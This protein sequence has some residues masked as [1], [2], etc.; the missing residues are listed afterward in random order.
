ME[1][2]RSVVKFSTRRLAPACVPIRGF[3]TP[4]PHFS[5]SN[6]LNPLFFVLFIPYFGALTSHTTIRDKSSDHSAK[7][8]FANVPDKWHILHATT[9]RHNLNLIPHFPPSESA[10]APARL[11]DG[12]VLWQPLR[13][14][15]SQT[16]QPLHHHPPCRSSSSSQRPS[17]SSASTCARPRLRLLVSGEL[18]RTLGGPREA[19]ARGNGGSGLEGVLEAG[20]DATRDNGRNG[21]RGRERL[22]ISHYRQRD[23]DVGGGRVDSIRQPEWDATVGTGT[24]MGP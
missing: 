6:P 17:R 14:V 7:R 16:T 12:P 21:Q 20:R 18:G 5:V 19:S 23:M 15:G 22:A 24:R 4:T 10:S 13:Q 9:T 1:R 8:H 11:G 3:P 2:E